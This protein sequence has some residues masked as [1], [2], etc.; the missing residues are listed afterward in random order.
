[1]KVIKCFCAF[2]KG[3]PIEVPDI[4]FEKNKDKIIKNWSK[5]NHDM[6]ECVIIISDIKVEKEK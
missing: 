3:E 5:C 4:S 1:M 2:I 6:R